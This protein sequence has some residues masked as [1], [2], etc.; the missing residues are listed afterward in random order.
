MIVVV[1]VTGERAMH[2]LLYACIGTTIIGFIL[3]F[4]ELTMGAVLSSSIGIILIIVGATFLWFRKRNKDDG[5]KFLSGNN[6]TPYR[7]VVLQDPRQAKVTVER[8]TVAELAN[9]GVTLT[10]SFMYHVVVHYKKHRETS[11]MF[12][13]ESMA[14]EGAK[15]QQQLITTGI[16]LWKAAKTNKGVVEIWSSDS[17]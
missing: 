5:E 4:G 3:L 6:R 11:F 10:Q 2:N 8:H 15:H 13:D 12:R 1:I 7:W 14:I 16:E 17:V 9:A